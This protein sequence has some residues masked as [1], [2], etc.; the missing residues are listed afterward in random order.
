VS[1]GGF[2]VDPEA[3]SELAAR[4]EQIASELA[5]EIAIFAQSSRG[6]RPE[7]FG[8]LPGARAAGSAYPRKAD[9]AFWGMTAI[10]DTVRDLG[11]SLR[12]A[13]ANY[14]AADEDAFT[15]SP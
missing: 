1:S 11:G 9:Q 15:G 7:A 4:F 14:L 6:V 3:L 12:T 13:A 10:Q 5:Q 2:R 8:L